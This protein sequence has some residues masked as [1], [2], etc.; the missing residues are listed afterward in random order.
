MA[1]R[2]IT[3][4]IGLAL[5]LVATAAIMSPGFR[6]DAAEVTN[7]V[8]GSLPE[9]RQPSSP[10][11]DAIQTADGSRIGIVTG[12][13]LNVRTEPSLNA[14]AI[15]GIFENHLVHIYDTITGDEV[16]GETDWFQIGDEQYVTA[17]FIEPFEPREPD[18]MHPGHWVDIDL[19][20][21]YAVA[22]DGDTPV[23][24]AIL[25]TGR[26]GW[27]TP[28]GKFEIMRRAETETMD[29]STIGI[30]E[31]AANYYYLEDVP[32]VQ[33]FAEGGYAIH[34]N[35]WSPPEAFGST[36]SHGCINMQVD[37]A[38]FFWDFLENGSPLVIAY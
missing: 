37:D 15:D 27:D 33:Y 30:L 36:G 26:A 5:L 35:D 9:V 19:T 24:A 34:G 22:Y 18:E 10:W 7:N 11:D 4:V 6:S 12:N 2:I 38:A 16:E 1:L 25:L 23:Y 3:G 8:S 31:D 21:H 32:Y 14:P 29:A 13:V 28:E 17:A 20:E